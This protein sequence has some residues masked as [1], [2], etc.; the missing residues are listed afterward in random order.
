[1]LAII[2]HA[3]MRIVGF[4]DDRATQRQLDE[5]SVPEMHLGKIDELVQRA[6]A[7]EFDTIYI[8]LRC[9]P[10]SVFVKCWSGW[11]IRG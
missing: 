2:L 4:F 8:T 9:E 5:L 10:S 3:R 11:A 6:Q 7:G 1:M